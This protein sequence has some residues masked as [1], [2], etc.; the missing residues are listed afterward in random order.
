MCKV[1]GVSQSSYYSW[2]ANKLSQRKRRDIELTNMIKQIHHS[3]KGRYGSPRIY[4]CLKD[5]G[6]LVSRKR[7]NRLMQENNIYSKVKGRYKVTTNSKHN[8]LIAPN[9]LNQNFIVDR[10]NQIWVSD[11]SYIAT[12]EGWLYLAITLDL[13][14]RKVVGWQVSNRI[15]KELVIT[16][17][18]KAYRSRKPGGGLIHHSDRGSQYASNDFQL[19]LSN[20]LAKPSMSG[21]GNCYDNAVAESF[22]K[23]LK[24]ELGNNNFFKTKQEAKSAIFE[25]I[26]S[27]YNGSRKHSTLNYCSPSQFEQYYVTRVA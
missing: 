11:I 9:L 15:T 23:S 10:P 4:S 18:L 21:K 3:V 2:R 17:Y 22:F 7:V 13:Y 24:T 27:F 25:Y 14:S 5:Q 20:T 19:I 12:R 8:H 6:E 1:F 16:A 26:E